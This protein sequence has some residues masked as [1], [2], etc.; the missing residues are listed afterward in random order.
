MGI[1]Y[2]WPCLQPLRP[3]T[4]KPQY[5]LPDIA[6]VCAYLADETLAAR[7]EEI[8]LVAVEYLRSGVKPHTLFGRVDALKFH[9]TMTFFAIAALEMCDIPRLRLFCAALEACSRGRL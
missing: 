8:T 2:V 1:W 5:L 3:G 9:E 4:S 6:S 7:L